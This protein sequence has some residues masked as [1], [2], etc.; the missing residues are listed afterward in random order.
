LK[1]KTKS[2]QFVGR[3]VVVDANVIIDLEELDS[4]F[5][6]NELFATVIIPKDTIER[7]LDPEIHQGLEKIDYKTGII[8]SEKGYNIYY[9]CLQ[10]KALSHC[11]RMSIAIAAENDCVLCTNEKPARALA[12][13]F[14]L[15]VT[16]TFGI[17]EAAYQSG[18]VNKEQIIKLIKYLYEEGSCYIS[19]T[20]LDEVFTQLGIS[21]EDW[22]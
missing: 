1:R 7:E 16:G 17:L 10:R 19:D 14:G 13:S 20:L 2:K 3:P 6:L 9:Q 4:L 5:L 15:E 21:I 11:D 12:Q 8:Q 18:V 22:E